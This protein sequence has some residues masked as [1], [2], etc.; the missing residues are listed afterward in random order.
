VYTI[1]SQNPHYTVRVDV[2]LVADK[3][4]L[5]N[6]KFVSM[7]SLIFIKMPLKVKKHTFG[8]Y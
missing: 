5:P 6:T 2:N 7:V 8:H 4:V 3:Q 1:S